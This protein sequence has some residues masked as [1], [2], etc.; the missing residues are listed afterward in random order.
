MNSHR[1]RSVVAVSLRLVLAVITVPALC[2]GQVKPL[3]GTEIL[4]TGGTRVI[5]LGTA[6]GPLPTKDRA[7]FSNLLI[8]NGVS[9]LVDAGDNVTRRIVQSG[10]DFR[11][12]GKVLIT[13]PH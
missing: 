13:H 1:S 9:Y 8:A 12:V 11:K 6:G 10:N 5:T 3:A 7:Q 2:I 4:A